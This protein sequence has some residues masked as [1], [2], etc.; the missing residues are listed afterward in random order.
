[1]FIKK[2]LFFLLFTIPIFPDIDFEKLVVIGSAQ[3]ILENKATYKT[4][5]KAK[6]ICGDL[7]CLDQ[8]KRQLWEIQAHSYFQETIAPSLENVFLFFN[9]YKNSTLD[10]CKIENNSGMTKYYYWIKRKIKKI[11]S[12]SEKTLQQLLV[13]K[14]FEMSS[15]Y[16]IDEKQNVV[17]SK[18]IEK[19]CSLLPSILFFSSNT[20]SGELF[21]YFLTLESINLENEAFFLMV[22]DFSESKKIDIQNMLSLYNEYKR[23]KEK[24]ENNKGLIAPTSMVLISSIEDEKSSFDR[25]KDLYLLNKIAD[26]ELYA[27]KLTTVY[28]LAIELE[29]YINECKQKAQILINKKSLD[30]IIASQES[31]SIKIYAYA[32]SEEYKALCSFVKNIIKATKEPDQIAKN[33]AVITGVGLGMAGLYYYTISDNMKK[34]HAY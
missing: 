34:N 29:T 14:I 20:K 24:F 16:D 25:S 26:A 15:L 6:N 27:Q 4:I 7:L 30:S 8:G 2:I 12:S 31:R 3:Y 5:E 21:S 9:R 10:E 23:D 28:P 22:K 13:C 11:F 1:M 33:F 18:T 19:Y 17:D 32:L